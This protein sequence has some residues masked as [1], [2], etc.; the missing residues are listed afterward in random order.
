MFGWTLKMINQIRFTN[1]ILFLFLAFS[2]T[3]LSTVLILFYIGGSRFIENQART[4]LTDYS[5]LFYDS[6]LEEI[7]HSQSELA[8][9]SSQIIRFPGKVEIEK[10][11]DT[12]FPHPLIDFAIGY[13][14][15]YKKVCVYDKKRNQILSIS[16]IR[17]YLGGFKPLIKWESPSDY[18]LIFGFNQDPNIY[19]TTKFLVK[20]NNEEKLV[21]SIQQSNADSNLIFFAAL[22]IDYLIENSLSLLNL[23]NTTTLSV[24]DERGIIIN[25]NQKKLIRQFVNNS[26]PPASFNDQNLALSDDD[27]FFNTG[28]DIYYWKTNPELKINI[29]FKDSYEKQFSSLATLLVYAILLSIIAMVIISLTIT[30]IAKRFSISLQK[31]IDVANYVSKGYFD[32]KITIE[33]QDELGILINTFNKMVDNLQASYSQLNIVNKQL[34]EKI[35]ELVRTKNELSQKQRLALI[36]ETI[37]KISHEIQNKIGGMNIWLQNLEYQIKGDEVAELYVDEMKKELRVFLNMLID[38][39][40]F[41]GNPFL[42]KKTVA[43]DDVLSSSLNKYSDEIEKKGI[44]LYKSFY[45][46]NI[47]LTVDKEKIEEVFENIILNAIYFTP[48]NGDIRISIELVCKSITISFLNSGKPLAE[49]HISNLFEPFFTTKSSGS[50]LGLAIAKNV[51]DAHKGSIEASNCADGFVCFKITLPST[52]DQ[53]VEIT[54]ENSI[55]R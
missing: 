28:S 6:F 18:P 24:V 25:S 27:K 5:R 54:Y 35:E 12:S 45:R 51:I 49:E 19:P 43:I 16:P 29:L 2:F 17:V 1:K 47:L 48:E 40:K 39:K 23:P 38:F 13:P 22:R 53:T 8:G 52:Y 20:I 42:N 32:K 34:E 21:Y 30:V 50:G 46:K 7:K 36:G 15:K 37:S 26:I 3:L 11:S 14:E 55:S 31:V 4:N 10:Y 33:R 41:Y 9:L 44:K